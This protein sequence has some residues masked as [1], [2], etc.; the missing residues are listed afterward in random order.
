MLRIYYKKDRRLAKESDVELRARLRKLSEERV[1]VGL[2]FEA[3]AKAEK[4]SS[5]KIL[6]FLDSLS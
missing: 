5:T 6:D 1:R 4:L 3:I 2:L